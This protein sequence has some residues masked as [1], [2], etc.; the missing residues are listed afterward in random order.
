[1]YVAQRN[2]RCKEKFLYKNFFAC[3]WHK[4]MGITLD[5]GCVCVWVRVL[6]YMYVAQGNTHTCTWYMYVESRLIQAAFDGVGPFS[7]A[8]LAGLWRHRGRK[9]SVFAHGMLHGGCFLLGRP[10]TRCKPSRQRTSK[11]CYLRHGWAGKRSI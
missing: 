8:V 4:Y 10:H 11:C 7:P 3:T 1:M 2:F 5:S 6:V 9:V